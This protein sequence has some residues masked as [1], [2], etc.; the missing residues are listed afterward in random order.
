METR[1]SAILVFGKEERRGYP[2]IGNVAEL[3]RFG[4]FVVEES[5]IHRHRNPLNEATQQNSKL[6][7]IHE[8][9][10]VYIFY[11]AA[12]YDTIHRENC[13]IE[14]RNNIEQIGLTV[15]YRFRGFRLTH[16]SS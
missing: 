14:L 15:V 6:C 11:P 7:R 12:I 4:A 3:E 10:C 8:R 9:S 2:D 13:A 5:E 16:L 1:D